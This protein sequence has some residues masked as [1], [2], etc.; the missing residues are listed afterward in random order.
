M[1]LSIGKILISEPFSLDPN[2]QR[3]IILLTE[4]D[5]NGSIG[6]VVNKPMKIEVSDAVPDFPKFKAELFYGGPVQPNTLH[7]IHKLGGLVEGSIE[8]LDGIFWGGNF[9]TV[10]ILVE[11]KQVKASDFMFFIGYSGWSPGQLENEME[12]KA[13]LLAEGTKKYLFS[14]KQENLW[15]NVLQDIGSEYAVIAK[16]PETPSL[17]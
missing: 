2:F 8:V 13:W 14:K 15:G 5:E 17:N 3:T 1:K 11:K 7:F 9:E 6:F 4:H 16:F 12:N 10:K